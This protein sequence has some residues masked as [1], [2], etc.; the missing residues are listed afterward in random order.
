MIHTY[1]Y[2]NEIMVNDCIIVENT[3]PYTAVTITTWQQRHRGA[4]TL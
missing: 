2:A 4:L 3:P 1:T